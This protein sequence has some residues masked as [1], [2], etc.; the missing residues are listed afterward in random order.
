MLLTMKSQIEALRALT[1]YTAWQLDLGGQHADEAARRRAQA[2]G[3]LLIPVVKACSTEAGIELASLGIQIHGGM[4]FV[5]ET[6]AAQAYRDVRITT[7]YEGTTAIQSNDF[8]GRK[9]ARDRG[10]AMSALIADM[11]AELGA[12]QVEH[13]AVMGARDATLAAVDEL[14]QATQGLLQAYM[15]GPERALAVSVPMVR[16]AGYVIGG[17]LLTFSAAIAAHRLQN[18]AADRDFLQGKI[19]SARF[20]ATHVLPQATAL[21]RVVT[22]GTS[23]VLDVTE[24]SLGR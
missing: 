19:D 6:G 10:E 14:E 11:R 2:R 17:W 4:G 1:L 3:D 9:L 8:A 15:A 5:E 22:S 23:S 7:I 13:A 16:L 21:A 12:L 18:G 24:A 20:Y